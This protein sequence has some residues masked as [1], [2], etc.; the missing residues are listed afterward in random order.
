M[1]NNYHFVARYLVCVGFYD[2]SVAVFNVKD[3]RPGPVYKSTAKSGKHTDPVWQVWAASINR[4][5]EHFIILIYC[6]IHIC[7]IN[8]TCYQK[9]IFCHFHATADFFFAEE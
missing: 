1:A 4:S 5:A 9:V 7:W 3:K 6:P 2:G 8:S